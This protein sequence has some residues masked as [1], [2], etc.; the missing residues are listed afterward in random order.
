MLTV[1]SHQSALK[2]L[3]KLRQEIAQMRAEEV[4]RQERA[5]HQSTTTVTSSEERGPTAGM[6]ER[7]GSGGLIT[8]HKLRDV[9]EALT[10]SEDAVSGT[11][12]III[13]SSIVMAAILVKI[14]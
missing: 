11:S 8:V 13:N 12:L 4:I 5:K 6:M 7:V 1:P 9:E 2:E 14:Y 3:V 10:Q